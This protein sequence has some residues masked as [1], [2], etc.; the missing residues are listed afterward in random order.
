MT[1][2]GRQNKAPKDAHILIS[3]TYEYVTWQRKTKVIDGIKVANQLAVKPDY[4][5][6]YRWPSVIMNIL[7][8]GRRRQKKVRATLNERLTEQTY[9]PAPN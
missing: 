2:C 4:Q 3:G 5:A 7:T 1:E 9:A 6:P 8:S